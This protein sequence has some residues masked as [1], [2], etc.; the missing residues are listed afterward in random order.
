MIYTTYYA[1]TDSITE[2]R[3]EELKQAGFS[4]GNA[5][6][7]KFHLRKLEFQ[8]AGQQKAVAGYYLCMKNRDEKQI[9]LEKKYT[10]NGL[11]FKKCVKLTRAE[12]EKIL[13][14]D[15]EW[16][17]NHRKELLAD[18]YLQAT[19][20]SLYPGRITD[21]QR[22]MCRVKK[23]EYL[24]FTTAIARGVGPCRSLFEEPEM[25]ISCLD[26]GKVL[27]TYKK[28]ASLPQMV[29]SMLQGQEEKQ[30]E[31]GFVF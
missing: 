10:Q 28:S 4:G 1:Q 29:S 30:D 7:E 22:E 26:E 18:F 6:I 23:G 13:N 11:Y 5:Q 17:K 9:F 8:G 24:T 14:G 27:L 20:N 2:E 21:Y 31:D 16:M 3:F 15:L 12:C 19:L 25:K